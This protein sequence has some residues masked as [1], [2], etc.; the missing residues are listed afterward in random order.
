VSWQLISTDEELQAALAAQRGAPAVAVDTEFMRQDTFFPRAAL[1]QLCFE[2]EALLIDP[3]AISDTTPVTELL[4]NPA[5]TKVLHSASEDLEVFQRWLGVMPRPLF[6]TQRAAALLNHGFSLGY[7]ALVERLLGVDLPKGETRSDWLR[8]PLSNS[9]CRYA[10]QDVTY[11]RELYDILLPEAEQSGKLAWILADGEYSLRSLATQQEAYYHKVKNGWKLDRRQQ[12]ALDEVT[13]WR[14]QTARDRDKP[15]GWI[16]DDPA[17]LAIATALPASRE[18][19]SRL[20]VMHAGALRRYADAILEAVERARA[21]PESSLPAP[22]PAP[23][24]PAQREQVKS[25]RQLVRN[26]GESLDVAPEALIQGKDYEALVRRAG[27]EEIA[28]P[29]YWS[30]WREPLVIR[31]LTEWLAERRLPEQRLPEHRLPEHRLPERT[32]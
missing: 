31:P 11:L 22:L 13:R 25:L 27:G 28:A 3:L 21:L 23:L 29:A 26:I 16:I 20:G 10:A 1:L 8:R 5:I 6:D 14:E 15:R 32:R 17:C 2:H 9:Q 19:L 12:A 24:Q 18:A 30:G 7:R 4:Q